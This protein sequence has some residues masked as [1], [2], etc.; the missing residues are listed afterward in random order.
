[1][2]S[3][4]LHCPLVSIIV[5]LFN[6]ERYISEA[7]ESVINQT[8]SNWELI[9]VDDGSKDQSLSIAKK[10][11][12]KKIKIYTKK[13][14]GA[15]IARNYGYHQS[16]GEFIK[17]FDADDLINPEMIAEQVGLAVKN[18]K[19]IISGKW[20]RFYD[21]DLKSF[22]LN[23]E[24]CW[25]N[26]N[27][28]DWISLSWQYGQSMT[29][30]GIFLVPRIIIEETGL[31]DERL[32][33]VDDM[34]FYTKT[35]LNS[36]SVLFCRKSTLYYRSGMGSNALSGKS[37]RKALK[38][39]YLALH[40]STGYLI[41]MLKNQTTMLCAANMWQSFIYE[42]YPSEMDLMAKAEKEI[43]RLGGSNIKLQSGG[44]TKFLNLFL[45]WK[46]IKQLKQTINK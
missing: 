20:G 23:E 45:G 34:E 46:A 24:K 17:F 44:I 32:S 11:E 39:H 1:M 27:P 5:P 35:I 28:I 14:K 8:Y 22:Q 21:D 7:I 18:P 26:L 37:S 3:D 4:H 29:Q 9:I 19:S 6:A 41:N 31:W 12:S 25:K 13:N 33:L 15:A 40:L 30:P 36:E 2:N 43:E 38:S 10:Y 16:K 42:Y